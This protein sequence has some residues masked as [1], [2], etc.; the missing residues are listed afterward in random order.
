MNASIGCLGLAMIVLFF[1][2]CLFIRESNKH[3]AELKKELHKANEEIDYLRE[4]F[5]LSIADRFSNG[6]T[7]IV[8]AINNHATMTNIELNDTKTKLGYLVEESTYVASHLEG[9]ERT[10][11]GM[12]NLM[13]QEHKEELDSHYEEA[14]RQTRALY[15]ANL[16]SAHAG[17]DDKPY[18]DIPGD[19]DEGFEGEESITEEQKKEASLRNILELPSPVYKW[20]FPTEP[21]SNAAPTPIIGEEYLVI[22]RDKSMHESLDTNVDIVSGI[23]TWKGFCAGRGYCSFDMDDGYKLDKVYAFIQLP[24]PSDVMEKVIDIRLKEE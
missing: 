6:L 2:T 24:S 12:F 3:I 21:S 13:E 1:T 10:L 5:M 11:N 7:K 4:E 20:E 9:L 15:E 18:A 19:L 8:T 22:G 17:D 16:A 23:G 14:K